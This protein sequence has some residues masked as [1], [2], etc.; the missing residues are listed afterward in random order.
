MNDIQ[1]Y[2]SYLNAN[3]KD[4]DIQSDIIG[5]DTKDVEMRVRIYV[6]GGYL[7][8][9]TAQK[10]IYPFGAFYEDCVITDV[11]SLEIYFLH[12]CLCPDKKV[13]ETCTEVMLIESYSGYR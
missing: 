6:D 4:E 11:I 10:S 12:K 2:F 3:K 7:G 9:D 13:P 1:F 8:S 5:D